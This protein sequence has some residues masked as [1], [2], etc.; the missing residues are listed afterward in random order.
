MRKYVNEAKA[1]GATAIICSPVPRN[2]F[3]EGKISSDIYGQWARQTADT[4]GAFFIDINAAIAAEYEKMGQEKV[5]AFFP[6]DH[7]HTNEAGARLN[8]EKVIEGIKQLKKCDLKK[9]IK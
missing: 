7:T 5:N 8:V 6:A 9:Y 4:T 1:K 3:K 2:N